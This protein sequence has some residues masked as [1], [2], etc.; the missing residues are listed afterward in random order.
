MIGSIFVWA[1]IIVV[2]WV[3]VGYAEVPTTNYMMTPTDAIDL[4][5]IHYLDE[6]GIKSIAEYFET[7]AGVVWLSFS[8]YFRHLLSY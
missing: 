6:N 3:T 7:V 5:Y 8:L 2:L 1:L 4:Q